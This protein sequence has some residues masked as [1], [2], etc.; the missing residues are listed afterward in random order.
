MFEI[1]EHE[2]F[3]KTSRSGG[4][5]GQNVNKVNTRVTVF[6]DVANSAC[7]S[8]IEKRRIM[9]RLK[10]RINK[11]GVIYVVSQRHRSQRA[12]REAAVTRLCELLD[13][14]SKQPRKRRKTAVP[15]WSKQRR[16]EDKKRRSA[17]KKQRSG[18]DF[19]L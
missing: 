9:R 3:F 8:N 14:A 10:T 4:P 7:F 12:N 19:E 1:P 2:L 5:G 17:L 13:G 18:R 6:F 16:L 11:D 15:G